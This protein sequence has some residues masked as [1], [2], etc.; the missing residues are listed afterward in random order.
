ME[1]HYEPT[2]DRLY[3]LWS[4]FPSI[5][6][7]KGDNHACDYFPIC[8]GILLDLDYLSLRFHIAVELCTRYDSFL[9][10]SLINL[11]MSPSNHDN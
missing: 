1:K 5:Y 3:N 11:G 2:L 10:K 4:I 7:Q 9:H 6:A 8:F